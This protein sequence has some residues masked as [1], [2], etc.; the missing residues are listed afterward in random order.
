MALESHL[1]RDRR[2]WRLVDPAAA[3]TST[4]EDELAVSG[5]CWRLCV[6]L[7]ALFVWIMLV[8]LDSAVLLEEDVGGCDV[9]TPRSF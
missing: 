5:S 2:R 6:C 9:S 1:K 8:G 4:C 7:L 3:A